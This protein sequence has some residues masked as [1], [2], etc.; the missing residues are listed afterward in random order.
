GRGPPPPRSSSWAGL[1][2]ARGSAGR[3]T[4]PAR[5]AAEPAGTGARRGRRVSGGR[6]ESPDVGKGC[7]T[8][9]GR[10]SPSLPHAGH[11]EVVIKP[12][13]TPGR[14]TSDEFTRPD[15]SS[16]V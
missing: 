14:V 6:G 13:A 7:G 2:A 11:G 5:T 9:G 8:W 16:L 15:R 4:A 10:R 3:G 12:P 1:A